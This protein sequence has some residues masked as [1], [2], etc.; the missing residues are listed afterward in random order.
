MSKFIVWIILLGVSLHGYLNPVKAQDV[1]FTQEELNWINENPVLRAGSAIDVPPLHYFRQ[2][3]PTGYSIDYMKLVANKAGFELEFVNA[4]SHGDF[5]LMLEQREIDVMHSLTPSEERRA[6]MNFTPTYM[7]VPLVYFGRTGSDQIRSIEDLNGQ[8]VG[9]VTG[10]LTT[11]I[12]KTE[13]PEFNLSEY[14]GIIEGLNAISANEIDIFVAQL[15]V[16]NY[17]LNQ[18]FISGVEVIGRQFFPEE[19]S[20]DLL[21]LGVRNDIPILT[22]ILIKAAYAVTEQELSVISQRW[23]NE[24]NEIENIGL[25]QEELEFL[26]ENQTFLVA[27]DPQAAPIEYIDQDG[28]ISG[29]SGDYLNLIANKLNVEFKWLGNETIQDGA[30]SLKRGEADLFSAASPNRERLEYLDFSSSYLTISTFIFARSDESSFANLSAMSGFNFAQVAGFAIT[31]YIKENYPDINITE[32]T[33]VE[34]ALIAVN[35]GEA[36]A[37]A[38]SIP[39]AASVISSKGLLHVN[40]IGESEFKAFISIGTRKELPLLSSAIEKAMNSITEIEHNEISKKWMATQIAPVSDYSLLFRFIIGAI[41]VITFVLI[42]NGKLRNEI[43]RRKEAELEMQTARREAEEASRAK[44]AFLANMSHEIRTPLNAIIGFSEVMS[45]G[46]FGKIQNEKYSEYLKD[47]HNSGQHLATVINDILDLSKIEAGKWKLNEEEFHINKCLDD[48]LDMFKELANTKGVE[49]SCHCQKDIEKIVVK[50]DAHCIMR[51]IINL[52]S[53][54][55]KFTPENGKVYCQTNIN[56]TGELMI[57]IIDTGVGIPEDRIDHVVHPFDQAHDNQYLKEE[58]TGL[59]LSIVQN[60]VKLHDG[61][62]SIKSEVGKG[63]RATITLPANRV[64]AA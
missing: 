60:L 64:I 32:Y 3:V 51:A 31:T 55:V 1:S 57:E 39:S 22:D 34:D 26:S 46:T 15:P 11:E 8:R 16:G 47:I 17:T 48:A 27:A 43:G 37:Y 38:G 49:M 45:S 28:N 2:G 62:F 10:W 40:I 59:G 29:I 41:A 44:S 56:G 36:D 18:H 19:H 21:A 35:N 58:G 4:A 5:V 14:S 24:Y 20:G 13:H 63:T 23:L 42:W 53:N 50:G 30:E 33:S 6:H 25:T 9:A 7:N 12:Y 52:I 54:S 61:N